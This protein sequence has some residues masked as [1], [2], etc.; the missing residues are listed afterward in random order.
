M[1]Y[2]LPGLSVH[3]TLV[4][5]H[6]KR[7]LNGLFGKASEVLTLLLQPLR[8]NL[9]TEDTLPRHAATKVSLPGDEG[10]CLPVVID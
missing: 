6:L 10:E 4:V 1:R 7:L 9:T 2:I 8:E 5:F 3:Q